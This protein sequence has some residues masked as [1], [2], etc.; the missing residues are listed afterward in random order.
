MS[1]NGSVTPEPPE[2]LDLRTDQFI[3]L[4]DLKAQMKERHDAEMKPINDAMEGL[5]SVMAKAM[6]ALHLDSV[7]T[8]SGTVSFS[9]KV[10]VSLADPNAFWNHCVVTGNFDMVDKK[11]NPTAV[12]DYVQKNGVAPPGVNYHPFRD[13]SVRRKS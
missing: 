5:K 2:D 11:A 13:V 8:S 6:D 12:K 4:R 1:D 10:N 7:K 9:T 3:R